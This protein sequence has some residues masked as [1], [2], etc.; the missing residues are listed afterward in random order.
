MGSKKVKL[1]E[2]FDLLAQK[3]QNNS[4]R[5]MQIHFSRQ[6]NSG[7]SAVKYDLIDS[8]MQ[9][10]SVQQQ[11]PLPFDDNELFF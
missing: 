4:F 7:N 8:A 3:L 6:Q 10:S 11:T 1:V 9:H 5:R 2:N